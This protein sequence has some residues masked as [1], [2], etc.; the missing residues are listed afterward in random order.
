MACVGLNNVPG[1]DK[2]HTF[3]LIDLNT[4]KTLEKY[5]PLDPHKSKYL[6]TIGYHN[7]ALSMNG[8]PYYY[9]PYNDTIYVFGREG[10]L[11][12]FRADLMGK[13]IPPSFYEQNYY[14]VKEFTDARK[15]RNYA[16]GTGLFAEGKSSFALLYYYDD[17]SW[18]ALIPE[19]T[20]K[21]A[22]TSDKLSE[23]FLLDGYTFNVTSEMFAGQGEI[24]IPL[25]PL[26]II[27]S[28]A[29]D[30]RDIIR[31]TIHYTDEDQ[32]PGIL[33]LKLK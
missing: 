18:L 9:E 12:V 1:K 31:Q 33:I 6:Y 3:H 24:I 19:E 15:A 2:T 30:K 27:E 8:K 26:E 28:V 21:S 14:D 20:G 10:L 4:G 22:V 11:P 13:S 23:T 16:F 25:N 5:I 17:K 29:A 32:N 7:F